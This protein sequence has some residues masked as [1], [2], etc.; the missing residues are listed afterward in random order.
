M[1]EQQRSFVARHPLLAIAIILA[2]ELVLLGFF[3]LVLGWSYLAVAL[4]GL[5]VL[6]LVS[7]LMG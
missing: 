7:L 4:A 5:V 2:V 6:V 1:A 3:H